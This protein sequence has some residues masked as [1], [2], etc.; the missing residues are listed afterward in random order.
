MRV[1]GALALSIELLRA[2]SAQ[3]LAL[4]GT[5]RLARAAAVALQATCPFREIRVMSRSR[6]HRE[7]FCRDLTAQGVVGLR[8]AMSLEAACSGADVILTIT[9]ANEPLVRAAWCGPGS[10]LVTAGGGQECEDAAILDADRIVVDDW[11]QCTL[12]GDLAVLHR[13]GKLTEHRIAGTLA[14][15]VAGCVPARQSAAE[16]LV[17]VPQGLTILD[18]ALGVYVYQLAIQRGLG[19]TVAG[20]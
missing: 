3:T 19:T 5:G 11:A 15:V 16:R 9:T 10:L 2:P 4:L 12:L 20:L 8:P 13:Q 7:Q 6:E 18:V 1:G 17:A 14:D